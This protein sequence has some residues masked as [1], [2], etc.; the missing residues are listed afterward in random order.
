MEALFLIRERTTVPVPEI[1]AWGLADANPLGLGPF[2][3]MDFIDGVCL[4]DIFTRGDSRLLKMEISDSDLEIVYRRI[5]MLR[6][7]E[8]NFD[9]IGSLPALRT[10]YS[11][12]ARPL[13]RKAQEIIQTGVVDTFGTLKALLLPGFAYFIYR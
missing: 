3:L 11:S 6:I 4:N 10:V 7:F 13:T 5:V 1:R 9:R 12:P 2:I 8:I